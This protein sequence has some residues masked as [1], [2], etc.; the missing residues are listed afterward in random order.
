VLKAWRKHLPQ[1]KHSCEKEEVVNF[2][3]IC[4]SSGTMSYECRVEGI[5]A[6]VVL[7]SK[8][9]GT[10]HEHPRAYPRAQ[11]RRKRC[12][13]KQF[14]SVSISSN[15]FHLVARMNRSLCQTTASIDPDDVATLHSRGIAKDRCAQLQTGKRSLSSTTTSSAGI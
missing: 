11:I 15:Y 2:T 12:S 9:L 5:G 6:F 8:T 14:Q 1:Y 4:L 10:P 3:L 13:N 7:S